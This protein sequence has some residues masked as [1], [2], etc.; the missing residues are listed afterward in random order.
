ML[1]RSNAVFSYYAEEARKNEIDFDVDCPLPEHLPTHEPEICA[2]LG[3]LLENA[4]DACKD[5]TDV[6]PF[7]RVCGKC[8]EHMIILAIDNTC[9]NEPKQ[10]N[11]RFLSTKHKGYGTGTYSVK[12]TA[13]RNGGSVKFEY[14]NGVF[15]ASVLLYG[16]LP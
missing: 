15:Y 7:I 4:I 6:A 5:L 13:E 11:G 10:E 16:N 1:F 14:K 3:N 12:A 2:L 8:Q 9:L